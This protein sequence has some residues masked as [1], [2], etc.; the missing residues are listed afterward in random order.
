MG[1]KQKV[2]KRDILNTSFTIIREEGFENLTARHIAA[3]LNS[4]TQPIYKEFSGMP[5]VKKRLI[6]QAEN[7]LKTEVLQVNGQQDSM[8]AVCSN[9]IQFTKKEPLFFQS[10]FIDR[11]LDVFRLHE[12]VSELLMGVMF[13]DENYSSKSKEEKEYL[14]HLIWA[15]IHGMAVLIVQRRTQLTEEETKN[16]IYHIL[17][18]FQ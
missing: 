8:M 4:S 17:K 6:E 10:L 11:A 14:L 3:K 13:L 7:F 15:A 2:T 16:Q 12:Y 9:Y 5:Q 1:R 18:A